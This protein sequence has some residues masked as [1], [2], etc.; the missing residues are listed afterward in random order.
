MFTQFS[1]SLLWRSLRRIVAVG[2]FTALLLLPLV[3]LMGRAQ[4][5]YAAA[6]ADI[7]APAI[8]TTE[9][10]AAQKALAFLTAKQNANGSIT[11]FTSPT[12]TAAIG[13][14]AEALFAARAL[15]V[16]PASI[17][18]TTGKS[19]LDPLYTLTATT[20]IS[21]KVD[22]MGKLALGLAAANLDPRNFNGLDLVVSMTH[23]YS[24][25]TGAFSTSNWDQSLA[26]LGWKAAGERIPLTA[27]NLLA[28]RIIS[29]AGPGNGGFEFSPGFGADTNS[30]GLVLQ[31]LVAGGQ[32]ITSTEV[33]SALAYLKAAQHTDGG[34]DYDG[35]GS[36]SD[37]NSTAYVLQG[38]LAVG[39]DPFTSTWQI[40]NT[41][42]I[43][44]LLS[45]QQPDGGF[46][47]LA[48]PSNGFATVQTIPALAGRGFPYLSR[49]VALRKGLGYVAAQLK[50]DGSF[51]GVGTGSAIDAV[52]AF[53]SAG[54][55]ITSLISVS[56]STPLQ[57]LV[58]QAMTYPKAS[59]A[60]AG[61][62]AVGVVAAG[63]NLRNV[64]GLNLVISMTNNFSPTTGRYGSTVWDES[65]TLLG[66]VA[67]G[68][69]IS[70]AQVQQLISIT[71]TGGGWDFGANA[72]APSADSTGL[73]LMALRAAGVPTSTPA[74]QTAIAALHNL[75]LGDGGFG[76]STS[77][78]ANSMGLALQG[79]C[80]YTE[81]VSSLTWSQVVTDGNSSRLTVR[82][83]LDTLLDFQLPDGGFKTPFSVP[84]AS[85][86]G[87]PGVACKPL[88]LKVAA[89]LVYLP[90]VAK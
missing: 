68:E 65:W 80:A 59:A 40:S 78:D 23:Y 35:S 56:G 18:T 31:A 14:V 28:S 62:Y 72:S 45:Q 2:S 84:A 20:Y 77:S 34:W 82:A 41:N 66:L 49:A 37:A 3:L 27:T 87:L 76:F 44:F 8:T 39:Q 22:R 75:Q 10:S 54:G 86:A 5:G 70:P 26:M 58:S 69:T 19:L 53:V 43:S 71:A 67:A 61:K 11:F 12:S 47:Y 21:G 57:F 90:F 30:T 88:P 29:T 51:N 33:L 24:P 89:R 50:P 42:P 81:P 38:L 55:N 74:V 73:A 7:N 36:A 83:A 4:A 16:N 13:D 79:L 15:G 64:N 48:P 25:T 85:Y 17:V 46:I 63:G 60:A 52:N 1:L 9:I 32:A 6:P